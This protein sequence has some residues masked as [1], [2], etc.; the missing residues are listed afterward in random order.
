MFVIAIMIFISFSMLAFILAMHRMEDKV[1]L[2]NQCFGVTR[3]CGLV[4]PLTE[5][6]E[7][8]DLVYK[9]RFGRTWAVN[10]TYLSTPGTPLNNIKAVI[11]PL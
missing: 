9:D 4:G 1:T 2:Y 11:D 7:A 10:G 3:A 6:E 8:G 5:I